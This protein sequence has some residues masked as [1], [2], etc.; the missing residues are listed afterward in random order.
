MA[1]NGN[2]QT[3]AE[4]VVA[5]VILGILGRLPLSFA[6]GIGRAMGFLAY[7]FAGKLRRT[8]QINLK[9]AFPEKSDQERQELLRGCFRSLGR[10]LGLFSQFRTRSAE[11]LRSMFEVKDL[12]RYESVK[13]EVKGGGIVLFTGHLGAWELT[14]FGFSVIGHPFSFLVRKIDNPKIEEIVDQTRIRFGNKT[15]DKFAAARGMLKI[16]RAG[17]VLGLLI[18]L[19]TLD[20]EAIF[21]DFFGV[22]AS[23]NFMV[24]KL[25]LRNQTP[26][27]PLLAPWDDKLKKYTLLVE[28]PIYPEV[29]GDEEADIRKL[30]TQL[31]LVIENAIRRFPDQWLWIHRR[32]KTRPPGEPGIY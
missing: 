27:V 23:T 1:K 32:W 2:L 30:T 9:L 25:A 3:T 8:G 11:K 29:S 28:P 15:I 10:E 13:A 18:D 4:Y 20:E 21:V 17:G 31:S 5:R 7:T 26:I 22:P 24:A 12:Q 16:L 19:N 6:M 14:S